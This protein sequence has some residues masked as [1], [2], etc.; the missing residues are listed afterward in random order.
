L[1]DSNPHQIWTSD[2]TRG[3]GQGGLVHE[4]RQIRTEKPGVRGEMRQIHIG[5]KRGLRALH[6]KDLSRPLMSGLRTMI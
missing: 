2:G 6:P 4:V 1:A 5:A 3:G